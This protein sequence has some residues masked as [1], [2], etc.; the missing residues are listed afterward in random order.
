M[1]VILLAMLVTFFL[2]PPQT[3]A[4]KKENDKEPTVFG[5]IPYGN[6]RVKI[7]E[8][9]DNQKRSTTAR[10][11]FYAPIAFLS[12][13]SAVSSFNNVT[14]QAE[15]R[16]EIVMWNDQIERQVANYLTNLLNQ[17]IQLSQVQVLPLEKVL[18]SSSKTSPDIL[19]P[20]VWT[21]YQMQKS[22]QFTVSCLVQ[23]DCDQLANSM[24]ANVPEDLFDFGFSSWQLLGSLALSQKKMAFIRQDNV[25]AGDL[26]GDLLKRPSTEVWLTT[27]DENRLVMETKTIIYTE[28]FQDSDVISSSSD[29]Q[30]TSLVRNVLMIERKNMKDMEEIAPTTSNPGFSYELI[31]WNNSYRPD[32]V[33]KTLT[34]LYNSLSDKSN[35][36][37]P[38]Q[39]ITLSNLYS[40][41]ALQS[42]TSNTPLE[43][44]H[45]IISSSNEKLLDYGSEGREGAE[46]F[47]KE[48][49]KYVEWEKTK[50]VSK[51]SLAK[52]SLAV[53]RAVI[54]AVPKDDSFKE[55]G[56]SL[57]YS[58]TFLTTPINVKDYLTSTDD[59]DPLEKLKGKFCIII[60][61]FFLD[62]L[63]YCVFFI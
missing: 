41:A 21:S 19:L 46:E 56:L 44:W 13:T 49:K 9:S 60:F 23:N 51:I 50:F 1:W 48:S 14:K 6:L 47:Y 31:R 61:V 42:K 25:F 4:Q 36:P 22:L 16:F 55:K 2:C 18:L 17:T 11:Y 24:K 40:P 63:N 12:P 3:G 38:K 26:A 52:F 5:S 57:S 53:L 7:Y 35:D 29:K 58:T 8:H 15:V 59:P 20:S 37:I 10:M 33:V 39:K 45:L 27:E 32:K 54:P 28:T 30:F 43:T 34:E 62:L